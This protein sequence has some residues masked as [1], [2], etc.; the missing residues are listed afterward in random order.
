MH[1]MFIPEVVEIILNTAW[2]SEEL[3]ASRS[4]C[5]IDDMAAVAGMFVHD[6]GYK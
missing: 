6:A 4:R 2:Y 3:L 1:L 5:I